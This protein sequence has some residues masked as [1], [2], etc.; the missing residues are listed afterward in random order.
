MPFF[1]VKQLA[2]V[3]RLAGYELRQKMS[4]ACMVLKLVFLLLEKKETQLTGSVAAKMF[5]DLLAGKQAQYRA[6]LAL[7]PVIYDFKAP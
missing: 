1:E 7:D 3:L 5:I 6:E 2:L 4:C